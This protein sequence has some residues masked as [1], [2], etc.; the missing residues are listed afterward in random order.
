MT[1]IV[2]CEPYSDISLILRDNIGDQHRDHPYNGWYIFVIHLYQTWAK[3]CLAQSFICAECALKTSAQEQICPKHVDDSVYFF[4]SGHLAAT[5]KGWQITINLVALP[6]SACWLLHWQCLL[7][8]ELSPNNWT[9]TNS[10]G[11]VPDQGWH[12]CWQK[13]G[14]THLPVLSWF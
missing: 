14:K 3:I 12:F 6:V 11:F 1:S 13:L 10:S 9:N 4:Q 7:N 8:S 5:P 2:S